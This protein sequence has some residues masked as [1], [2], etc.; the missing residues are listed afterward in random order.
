VKLLSFVFPIYNESENIDLLYQEMTRV[1]G[2]VEYRYELIFVN[3]G[4]ADDSLAKLMALQRQDPRVVVVDFARNFGHQMAVTAGL[5]RADG[6]AVVIMDSDLQD[7]PEVA[8]E[9]VAKWEEGFDVVYAQRRSREDTAFKKFTANVYYRLLSSLSDIDIPRNTGDFRLVDRKVVLELRKYRE[10][11]RFLRGMVSY[12]GFRQTAVK[13]DRHARHAGETGYPLKKM[14]KF[15]LDGII[16]FSD[17]P[18]RLI[19]Q[20]GVLMAVISVLGIIYALVRRIFFPA[21]V[22]NGWTFTIIV[23]LLVGGIQLLMMGIMGTYL[24]RIYTQVKG[25]PLYS[26]RSIASTP[27][28]QY[29]DPQGAEPVAG[30]NG[31]EQVAERNGAEQARKAV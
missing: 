31:A 1:L 17:K 8:L 6:D 11:D 13:F 25:R 18:L 15:A 19:S 10:Q 5:D 2:E 27:G 30:S 21:Q 16:G 14:I 7:P 3:D 12:V 23:V 26:V 28:A 9:L 24:G 29:H 20:V 22:V 4:S